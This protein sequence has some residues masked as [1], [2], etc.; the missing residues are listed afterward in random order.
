MKPIAISFLSLLISEDKKNMIKNY[1]CTLIKHI[2]Y[3]MC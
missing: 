1:P 2:L 3:D